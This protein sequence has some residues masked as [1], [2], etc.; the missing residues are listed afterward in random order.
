MEAPASKLAPGIMRD[1]MEQLGQCA[2]IT[3]SHFSILVPLRVFA[4]VYIWTVEY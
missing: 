3:I 4:E 1:L 2:L